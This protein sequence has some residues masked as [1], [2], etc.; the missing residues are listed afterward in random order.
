MTTTQIT[1]RLLFTGAFAIYGA[2]SVAI[3]A[4]AQPA[5]P[6]A[7]VAAAKSFLPASVKAAPNLK[8]T[9]HAP[10]SAPASGLTV[11]T[12]A[13]GYAR[14][15]AVRAGSGGQ[16]KMLTCSDEAGRT[17]SYSVDLGSDA[18]FVDR[19]HDIA[20]EP[21]IDRPA[22]TGDP[23]SY[24]QT[25][26]SQRG[27]GLRPKPS[28]PTYPVWVE[29]ATKSGRMLYA[30][31][32]DKHIHGPHTVSNGTAP[33]W[34]GSVMTG[35]APY[36]SITSTFEVPRAIPGADGTTSTEASLW[37]GLGGFNTGSGLI[38][39]GVTLYT[40]PTTAAYGTW[41]EY[42]CGDGDSNGY[43]GNFTPAPGDKIL[44]QAWYCDANGQVSISGGYG[45]S[46]LYDFRSGAVFSCT[47]PR[48]SPGSQPCWSV[49]ALPLCSAN[50][51]A[52][53]CMT[54]GASAE[55]IL[56]NQSPQLSP[57]MDQ[58]PMFTP[59]LAMSGTATTSTGISTV[60]VDPN[61]ILLTD[62]PH[63]LPHLTVALTG[64][65]TTSITADTWNNFVLAPPGRADIGAHVAALSRQQ[66]TMEIFWIGSDGSVQD[67]FWYEGSSWQ[68]FQLAPSGSAAPTSKITA[69]SR[70]PNSMEVFWIAP[71]GSVQDAFWYDG[72]P[73]KR[74]ELAPAGSASSSGG[75]TAVSRIPTSMEVF[76]IA[77]NGSV[78]DA[79]WYDG[80]PWKQ[81]ELSPAGSASN[82]GGI[83]A[84]S[85]IP[86]SMETFWIALNGSVQDAFW[87][88]GSP[89]N[90]F[91]L[92]PANSASVT[93]AITSVS[94]K[95]ETMEV[96]WTAANGSVQDAFWY[97]GATWNRFELAP[98]GSAS[99]NGGIKAVARRPETMEVWWTGANGSIQDAFWYE[100]STWKRFDL[101]PGGR[102]A[103]G[104]GVAAVSR[105]PSSME[106]WWIGADRSVQD[107]YYYDD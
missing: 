11:F 42:C 10:G 1:S 96:F 19:P 54:L 55:F 51:S 38:Q 47:A 2:I 89:W 74:F 76:W 22:L 104:A 81:F 50:P 49:Q 65:G 39:A 23:L 73:W 32:P 61:V 79:F 31:K 52:P 48:G 83:T 40:T 60:D 18:T 45:C 9:L 27:Y 82:S 62:Y 30:R 33:P 71:N 5:S 8:C 25:E 91:E 4:Q 12:D 58:F 68:Q 80:S 57:P 72:S 93:G 67:A 20:S 17:S 78:Q 86:G 36:S 3:S 103:T 53:G 90:Q 98:P 46:Y 100:N 63:R 28:D 106:V 97:S 66:N 21:G 75:I 34:V 43:G 94:R 41:R 6:S 16:S 13:D 85:R 70:I 77:P 35:A 7:S 64:I 101:A 26:L 88:D 15:H 14:F 87:Y 105:I 44:A 92:A 29:A 84:V 99:A 24:T 95:P 56:E 69:V 59:T 37:P 107:N 102:A